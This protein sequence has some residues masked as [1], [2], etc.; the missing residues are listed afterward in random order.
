MPV[1]LVGDIDR[2]GVIASLVGTHAVLPGSRA[3]RASAASS[4]TSSAATPASSRAGRASSTDAHRLAEPRR[5]A[6]VRRRPTRCRRRMC[7]ASPSDRRRAAAQGHGRRA[8]RCRASPI[9]T[10][11]IRCGRAGRFGRARPA[12][13][14]IPADATLVLLPGSKATIADLAVLRRE[15]WDIDILAHRRRGGRVLGLCGGYQMLGRTIADPDGIEGR[16][17][18]GCRPRPARRRDGARRRQDD[19]RRSRGRHVASGLPDRRLRDPSRRAP[20]GPD[21][22]RPFARS[23]GPPGWGDLVRRP[24]RRD[25]P[26]RPLRRATASAARSSP[27]SARRPRPSPTR[28]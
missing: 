18:D 26:P 21:C 7:S 20:R 19:R 2:G 4:S 27:R 13:R 12:G 15:G 25:L 14:P 10:I 11:S 1:V 17:G 28:R 5:G 24:G 3:R 9:S 8:R 16:P 6:L 23:R 22:A